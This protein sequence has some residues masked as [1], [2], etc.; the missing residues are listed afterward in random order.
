[1]CRKAAGKWLRAHN[2]GQLV[3]GSDVGLIGYTAWPLPLLD[4]YG[5]VSRQSAAL[6]LQGKN[7]DS[8]LAG[9]QGLLA[10]TFLGDPATP[11][12]TR[13]YALYGLAATQQTAAFTLPVP[14]SNLNWQF[15]PAPLFDCANP[16]NPTMR[17]QIYQV[18][19]Q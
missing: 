4:M 15:A 2:N 17:V 13:L 18:S 19:W 10:D 16:N 1:L 7:R 8:L 3:V 14:R 12:A 11:P 9:R 5:L 6:V